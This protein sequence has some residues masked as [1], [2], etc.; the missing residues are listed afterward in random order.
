MVAEL[1]AVVAGQDDEGVVVLAGLA[2]E[3]DHPAHVVVDLGDQAVVGRA[4]RPHLVLGHR[5]AEAM[6]VAEEL[7]LLDRAHVVGEERVL[8]T[9]RVGRGRAHGR[10][11]VGRIVADVIRRRRDEGRVRAIVAEVQAPRAAAHAGEVRERALGGP[12]AV[13]QLRGH[14]RRRAGGARSR[15]VDGQPDVLRHLRDRE[16]AGAQP[17]EV[18]HLLGLPRPHRIP[19]R[20]E[21]AEVAEARV[22]GRRHAR[23]RRGRGVADQG[24]LVAGA[25]H[26]ER[27]VGVARVH[28]HRV[29]HD[30]VVHHV[31]PGVERG[32]AGPARHR[33]R[34][35][36]AEGHAVG[37]E[38]VEVRRAQ[39]RMP[40]IGQ[41]VGPPLVHHDEQDVL[42]PGGCVGHRASSGPARGAAWHRVYS[43]R[44]DR[45]AT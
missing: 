39:A 1:L 12:G 4:H 9:L 31:E 13:R 22:L 17:V 25:P 45:P 15:A 6:A 29:L 10:G 20:H 14:A 35:V 26:L 16:A 18:V 33:L 42:R 40:E 44:Q 8:A 36:V 27:Q 21:R 41:A 28:G 38:G 34:E 2:Q 30:P 7:R 32:P 37:A 24:R 5:R 43:R 11:H 19:P 23:V 3:R